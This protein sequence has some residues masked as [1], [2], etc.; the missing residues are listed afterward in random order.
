MDLNLFMKNKKLVTFF[1]WVLAVA[2]VYT[3]LAF[4]IMYAWNEVIPCIFNLNALTFAQ[5][6]CLLIVIRII[7][8]ICSI[9]YDD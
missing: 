1:T 6:V 2:I 4:I 9:K 3:I 5:A 7:A 8:M